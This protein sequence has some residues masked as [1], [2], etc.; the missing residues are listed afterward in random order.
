[1]QECEAMETLLAK[2]TDATYDFLAIVLPGLLCMFAWL[3]LPSLLATWM[4]SSVRPSDFLIF[5]DEWLIRRHFHES[6]I[7]LVMVAYLLVAEKES[8]HDRRPEDSAES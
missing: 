7:L 6:M 3:A 5:Y 8:R 1:M 2:L 4:W